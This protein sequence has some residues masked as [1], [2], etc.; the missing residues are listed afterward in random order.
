MD[1][2]AYATNG[3]QCQNGKEQTCEKCSHGHGEDVKKTAVRTLRLF[4]QWLKI[5]TQ[6]HLFGNTILILGRASL[7]SQ[8]SLSSC[9]AP[10]VLNI[11]VR[12][13]SML[14]WLHHA[15]SWRSFGCIFL[16]GES[17]TLPYPNGFYCIQTPWLRRSRTYV[18]FMNQSEMIFALWHVAISS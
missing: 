11:P 13:W 15:N 14:T 7:C 2:T 17:P 6:N 8:N 16:W 1:V 4:Q 10:D 18:S 12:F 5:C 3:L 9:I